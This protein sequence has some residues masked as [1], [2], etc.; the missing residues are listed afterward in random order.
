MWILFPES[1]FGAD[2]AWLEVFSELSQF[3]QSPESFQQLT[4]QE[5]ETLAAFL[6]DYSYQNDPV[7]EPE[8]T[9]EVLDCLAGR[10]SGRTERRPPVPRTA[11]CSRSRRAS[12]PEPAGLPG[13]PLRSPH[14]RQ[15]Q[16]E[17][18]I[19]AAG[20]ASLRSFSAPVP[21]RSEQRKELLMARTHLRKRILL[22]LLVLSLTTGVFLAVQLAEADQAPLDLSPEVQAD[23]LA[24]YPKEIALVE[25]LWDI[26]VDRIDESTPGGH[27]PHRQPPPRSLLSVLRTDDRNFSGQA[28]LLEHEEMKG[29]HIT[30]RQVRNALA[31]VFLL[32]LLL[33]LSLFQ[34]YQRADTRLE[35]IAAQNGWD[36]LGRQ[37]GWLPI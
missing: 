21:D 4:P 8:D 5:R 3:V 37:T 16:G 12:K 33:F 24:R 18:L 35:D 25:E 30:P 13:H 1:G 15:A 11:P 36:C 28:W 20:G 29:T 17:E 9:A 7:L 2:D 31:A 34:W 14:L 6:N 10:W 32:L 27:H 19:K 26:Q 23:L 22:P